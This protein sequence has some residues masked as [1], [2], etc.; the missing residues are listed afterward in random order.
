[1]GPADHL[2]RADQE[3]HVQVLDPRVR[4]LRPRD[5]EAVR[6]RGAQL[7]GGQPAPP[8]DR[9]AAAARPAERRGVDTVM[10]PE[11]ILQITKIFTNRSRVEMLRN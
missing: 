3:P 10:T 9:P 6:E 11:N 1:M 5:P 2:H 7:H 4:A 8:G